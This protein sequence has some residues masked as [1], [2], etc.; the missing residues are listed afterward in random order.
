MSIVAEPKKIRGVLVRLT[1]NEIA[2][3]VGMAR[4]LDYVAIGRETGFSRRGIDY[5]IK[6]ACDQMGATNSHQA[7]ALLVECGAVKVP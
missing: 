1:T 3:F 7:L 2:M 5:H 4:G 6:R